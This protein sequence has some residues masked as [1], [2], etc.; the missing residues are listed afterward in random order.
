MEGAALPAL[1]AL[2]SALEQALGV[3]FE[4]EK[5]EHFFR[6]M[7]VQT[8]FYGVFASWV[9]W[10]RA[11]GKGGFDWRNAAWSLHVPMIRALFEQIAVPAKLRPLGLEEPLSLTAATLNRVARRR[12]KPSSGRAFSPAPP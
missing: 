12:G 4:G 2:R 5:G 9:L 6:S 8:L 10:H 3:K 1:D 11:G 7:L